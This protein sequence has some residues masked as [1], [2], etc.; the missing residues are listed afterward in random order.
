MVDFIKD[1][2]DQIIAWMASQDLSEA[3]PADVDRLKAVIAQ[4]QVD[5]AVHRAMDNYKS[6]E[7]GKKFDD[8]AFRDWQELKDK[9][10]DFYARVNEEMETN[11]NALNDPFAL[12]N[13]ANRIGIEMGLLPAGFT[14][15]KSSTDPMETIGAGEGGHPSEGKPGIGEEFLQKTGKIA[16]AFE[17][18]IDINNPETRARIAK[19]AEA[20]GGPDNG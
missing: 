20:G 13:T 17:G 11:P 8:K 15:R 9:E 2:A 14:P 12:S 6:L 16:E 18:L 5:E 4:K 19:R 10:S 7:Q 1:S 3:N